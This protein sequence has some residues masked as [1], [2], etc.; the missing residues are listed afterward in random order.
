VAKFEYVPPNNATKLI[1]TA[2]LAVVAEGLRQG[3][4]AILPTETGYLLAALATSIPAVERAF[5]VKRRDFAKVMHVACSSLSMAARAGQISPPARRLLGQFTPGPLSVIVNKTELLPDRLVTL[6]NT[7]GL[8]IPDHPATLQVISE[9]GSPVTAT[10]LNE[11]G[12]AP[13]ALSSFDLD[14]L[15][16]SAEEVVFVVPDDAAIRYP[17]AST[18]VQVTG[19]EPEVLREGPVTLEEIRSAGQA[20]G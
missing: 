5:R 13:G 3:S 16:W 10:S 1:K 2:D 18:L 9:L 17:A 11:S 14:S 20:C 4:L 8:R 19:D 6:N 15:D 7:V 12:S